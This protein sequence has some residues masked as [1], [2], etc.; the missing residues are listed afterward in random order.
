MNIINTKIHTFSRIIQSKNTSPG[1]RKQA[2]YMMEWRVLFTLLA[3]AFEFT[4][5]MKE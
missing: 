1:I 2:L 5:S 3:N 4:V